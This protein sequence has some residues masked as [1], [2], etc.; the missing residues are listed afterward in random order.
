[1]KQILSCFLILL[2]LFSF[3]SCN[4]VEKILGDNPAETAV[5]TS[6]QSTEAVITLSA[7]SIELAKGNT[8][9][10]F[11][12]INP[13][14]ALMWRSSNENIVLVNSQGVITA[15]S[16]GVANVTCYTNGAIDAVCT[17][18][19][20]DITTQR[21]ESAPATTTTTPSYVYT[22]SND[23]IFPYSSSSYLTE[24]EIYTTISNMTGYSPTGNYAQDAINEIYAR[25]GYVFETTKIANFYNAKS[26]YYPN[27]SFGMSDLN[28]Y[29]QEN[30]A[31]LKKYV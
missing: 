31:L 4:Q 6:S 9:Q 5:A 23:F 1:M 11:G 22:D 13:P 24:Y 15:V 27:H 10:L 25:N 18:T 16:S 2:M 29:E 30:V 20:K 14:Q 3:C 17:V 8:Y 7:Y 21:V 28:K 26:W 12:T 19:V